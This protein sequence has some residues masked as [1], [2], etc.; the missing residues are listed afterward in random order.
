MDRLAAA[1]DEANA[2]RNDSFQ[3]KKVA[4]SQNKAS[5]EDNLAT[6]KTAHKK[7]LEEGNWDQATDLQERMSKTQTQIMALEA[8]ESNNQRPPAPR[9][10]LPPPD[11]AEE[12]NLET[13]VEGAGDDNFD[14]T[15]LPE[16][17]QEWLQANGDGLQRSAALRGAAQDINNDLLAEGW[18]DQTVEFYDELD[19]R[20]SAK[21]PEFG[22]ASRTHTSSQASRFQAAA[23]GGGA[24]SRASTGRRPLTGTSPRRSPN[25]VQ[26]TRGDLNGAK[27]LG[28][29]VK[30]WARRKKEMQDSDNPSGWTDIAT[31]RDG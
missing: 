5:L 16:P 29:D 23:A 21:L 15:S 8:Y 4:A 28:V 22:Q 20:I 14:I 31:N 24:T 7:A 18:D 25:R 26:L 3:V 13:E 6:I 19:N 1:Q 12:P 9:N 17:A 11:P 30:E 10:Y 2:L 27:E